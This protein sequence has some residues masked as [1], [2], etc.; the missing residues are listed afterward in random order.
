MSRLLYGYVTFIR[1]CCKLVFEE[2]DALEVL[3][4]VYR[5]RIIYTMWETLACLL[6]IPLMGGESCIEL[7]QCVWTPGDPA[8]SQNL[9]VLPPSPF[10]SLITNGTQDV[11]N[12]HGGS[13]SA[14]C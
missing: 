10:H 14:E 6:T 3:S 11:W 13:V 4:M 7:S 5:V 2:S 1:C 8:M 12:L 9:G